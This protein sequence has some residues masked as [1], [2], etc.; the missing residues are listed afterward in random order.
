MN[1]PIGNVT[2]PRQKKVPTFAQLELFDAMS[3]M[4]GF[5]IKM[6]VTTS[7]NRC[8]ARKQEK[9]YFS[10]FLSESPKGAFLACPTIPSPISVRT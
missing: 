5:W 1:S 4:D 3:K 7:T 9:T 8:K 10:W 6:K 2:V